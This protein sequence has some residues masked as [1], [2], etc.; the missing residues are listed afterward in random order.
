VVFAQIVLV[1]LFSRVLGVL[2]VGFK[3]VEISLLLFLLFTMHMHKLTAFV[4]PL[5]C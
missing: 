5:V 2:H 3:S 1:E 4:S